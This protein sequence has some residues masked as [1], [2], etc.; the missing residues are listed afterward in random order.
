MK[1]IT[2]QVLKGF[3][4]T[5]KKIIYSIYMK[6]KLNF[7]NKLGRKFKV[8]LIEQISITI[9]K[10]K[11]N[12]PDRVLEDIFKI[13]HVT[14]NRIINRISLYIS[15]FN[16]NSKLDNEFYIVDSTTLRIGKDKTKNSYSGYKHHHGVKFQV[17]VNDKSI[18]QNI[19]K[20][21]PSS[22]HDK[23]L[24]ICEYQ[25]LT[26][27]IDKSLKILGDKGY[28]G[29]GEYQLSIPIKR[30]E[31]E[32]KKDKNLAK[33]NN[34]LISRKR[35]KI[36]HVFAYM[37]NFRILQRLNYYKMNKIEL[38]FQSIANIYNLSKF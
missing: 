28:A 10:L 38:F 34:Q 20:A 9:F 12:L 4:H 18:I 17:I 31:R 14:I 37:K 22:I 33:T 27:K 19:S 25:N 8:G 32:Y 30:N 21:Y 3:M 35:I 5:Q 11:Y 16:L 29:L 36:E 15:K 1:T 6:I 13:D 2:M 26:N 7:K 23:K 24:F